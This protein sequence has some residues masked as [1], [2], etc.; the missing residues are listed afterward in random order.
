[1]RHARSCPIEDGAACDAHPVAAGPAPG[2]PTSPGPH[3][4]ANAGRRMCSP[5]R[6]ESVSHR[7]AVSPLS[8]RVANLIERLRPGASSR[9]AADPSRAC[10]TVPSASWP[11]SSSAVAAALPF[12]AA[13]SRSAAAASLPSR[14]RRRTTASPGQRTAV[15]WRP[16]RADQRSHPVR[17]G[18]RRRRAT[19]VVRPRQEG[20]HRPPVRVLLDGAV[21]T[22]RP[23]VLS[24]CL[25][26]LRGPSC[27]ASARAGRATAPG[28]DRSGTAAACAGRPAGAARRPPDRG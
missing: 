24:C 5:G 21:R 27:A 4:Q 3:E 19:V 13:L 6:R 22:A 23:R 15:T 12:A 25:S 10:A 16:V 17:H 11:Q 9:R 8:G 7:Q 1:M 20:H 18:G 2:G 26:P 28:P 14:R